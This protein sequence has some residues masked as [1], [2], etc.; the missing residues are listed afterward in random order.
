LP[1]KGLI[2]RQMFCAGKYMASDAQQGAETNY[3]LH[4]LWSWEIS[5]IKENRNDWNIFLKFLKKFIKIH[6]ALS[7]FH[8][9]VEGRWVDGEI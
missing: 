2:T 6:P 7:N 9:R 8:M 5:D 1:E 3:S 4:V